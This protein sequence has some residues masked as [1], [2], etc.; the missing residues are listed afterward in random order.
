MHREALIFSE[1]NPVPTRRIGTADI[2]GFG[3]DGVS[4]L[5]NSIRSTVQ[6]SIASFG[7]NAGGWRNEDHVRLVGD[8][9]GN[10]RSD[11]IGFGEHGVVVSY[12]NGSNNFSPPSLVLGDEFGA[13]AE[14]GRWRVDEHV[15][16]AADLLKR[17]YV[18]IIGFGDAGVLVSLNNGNGTFAT[19]HLALPQFGFS[20]GGYRRERHLRFLADVTGDGRPDIVGFGE[21]SVQVALNNGDGTFQKAR[22]VLTGFVYSAGGWRVD[23]H[24]R[25]LADL[26][27]DGKADI[28]GFADDGVHVALNN[29]NGTFQE[30]RLVLSAFGGRDGWQKGTHPRYVADVT[31][32][33]RGDIVGFANGG[34]FVALGN[35]DGTF[36]PPKHVLE[37]FGYE[38]G[39]WRVGKHPRYVVDLTGDGAADI[40][41]I[42]DSGVVVSYNDGKGNFE[43]PQTICNH[44]GAS[45][46]WDVEK[47]VRLVA[48]L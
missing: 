45:Q 39:G 47:T 22:P 3:M 18:D 5:R 40:V 38:A 15:R 6:Q 9:T 4:V 34:V 33:G 14:A 29:G 48:N 32:N 21:K 35:G 46:G 43:P 28:V 37:A 44:F 20:A 11:I 36:Q 41:G 2:V 42:S 12:N 23:K 16:Y 25:I 1:D 26:T 19:P 13:G 27:G 30:S 24:P 8:T 7:Y 10:G 31:G 17:G